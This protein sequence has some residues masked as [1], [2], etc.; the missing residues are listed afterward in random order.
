[1]VLDDVA[2]RA[3]SFVVSAAVLDSNLLRDR[4][5]HRVDQVGVPYRLENR[6]GK[7]KSKDVL[8][9]LFAEVVVDPEDGVLG[10]CLLQRLGQLTRRLQVRSKRFLHD[11]AVEPSAGRQ[12]GRLNLHRDQ[13]IRRR[14]G[15]AVEDSVTGNVPR[16]VEFL[17]LLR[18][19]LEVFLLAEI[20][21]DVRHGGEKRFQ[22]AVVD[23]LGP[24]ELMDLLRGVL[25]ERIVGQI[26]H[27][28]A[29]NRKTRGQRALLGEVV[30]SGQE[31]AATE[32][33][34][35]SE[36]DHDGRIGDPVVVETLG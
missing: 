33:T 28:R 21:V 35:G 31:L 13:R 19:S 30:Q 5:L 7:A 16:V 15:G 14:R 32:I 26:G 27:R 36:Y 12:A 24:R 29:D 25:A 6:V 20:D 11:D 34:G 10:K 1:M 3:G 17:Q 23:R 18:Q 9:G 22:D 2:H 8:D 4:D